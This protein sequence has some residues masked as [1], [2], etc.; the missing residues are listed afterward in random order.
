MSGLL[1][2]ETSPSCLS[3]QTLGDEVLVVAAGE[4]D[5]NSRPVVDAMFAE[6]AS[7]GCRRVLIDVSGV[8]FVDIAGLRALRAG[9]VA[10]D[11]AIEVCLRAPSRPVRRILELVDTSRCREMP[12][13]RD[14]DGHRRS[15]AGEP[16]MSEG[17]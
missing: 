6:V 1:K 2:F 7:A 5:L 4:F 10:D 16:V 13:A 14:G 12:A 8:T 3:V 11:S 15:A 9:P 17:G